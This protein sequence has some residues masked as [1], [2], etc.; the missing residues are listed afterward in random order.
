M[1]LKSIRSL[2]YLGA[3]LFLLAGFYLPAAVAEERSHSMEKL[4]T[5]TVTLP[6]EDVKVVVKHLKFPVGFKT[7]Q[8]THPG[9]GPRYVLRGTLEVK[10]GGKTQTYHAGEAFWESGIPMTAENTGQEEVEVIAVELI[11]VAETEAGE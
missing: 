6:S 8:H 2:L 5:K 7:P 4:L 1:L 10:E 11:P 9:P 3:A